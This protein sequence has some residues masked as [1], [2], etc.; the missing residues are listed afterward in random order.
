MNKKISYIKK[1]FSISCSLLLIIGLITI[2]PVK[3]KT[4]SY[5]PK[6]PK[7]EKVIVLDL[8]HDLKNKDGEAKEAYM[9]IT[10]IQGIINRESKTKI[11]L[12]HT[13]QEHDW[14]P[15]DRKSVV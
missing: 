13:P 12:T 15:L 1:V 2:N 3:A 4:N 9:A 8:S 14:T 10:S 6:T 5:L 11:Y 7:A